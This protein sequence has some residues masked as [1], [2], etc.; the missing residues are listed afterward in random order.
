MAFA[1]S[2]DVQKRLGRPL[3]GGEKETADWVI[4]TVTGLIADAVDLSPKWAEGL[5]RI[6]E[7]LKALCVEKA[8]GA[9]TN[10][11]NLA[12]ES[13][14]VGAVSRSRTFQR[15]NDVS[16]FLSDFEIRQARSAV[17]GG[18][19]GSAYTPSVVDRLV[20]LGEGSEP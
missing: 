5:T 13:R 19:C 18:G 12:A 6:P 15:S 2:D 7:G 14:T 4:A 3:T 17:F 10:P 16:V 11:A 1:T 8:I 9:I 20:E